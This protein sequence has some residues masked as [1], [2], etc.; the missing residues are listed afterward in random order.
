MKLWKK[1]ISIIALVAMF[2]FLGYTVLIGWGKDGKG[3]AKNIIL[4]LDLN[5]GV[6]VTYEATKEVTVQ[7]MNDVV[8]MMSDRIEKYDGAQAYKEGNDRVTVEIPGKDDALA[9]LEEL[10]KPGAVYFIMEYASDGKTKN[11]E[12]VRYTDGLGNYYYT[13][14]LKKTI[15]EIKEDGTII[16]T[17]EDIKNAEA[18]YITEGVN[19]RVPVVDFALNDSGTSKFK[20]ATTLAAEKGWTI[21][22]YYNG[23]FVSVPSVDEV[24]SDGRGIIKGMSTLD[25]AKDLAEDIRIGALPVELEVVSSQV[26]GASLGQDAISVSLI[27][28]IIGFVILFI[29]MI[30]VYKVPGV[31]SVFALAAYTGLV[32]FVLNVYNFSLTLPG[33]AG[34]ILGIGMAVDANVIVFARIKEEIAKDVPVSGAIR[35]GFK[36]ALSAIIDGNVTTLIAAIVLAVLGSGAIR[37][38]AITLIISIII[39]L[40]SSLLVTRWVLTLLYHLG[41]KAEKYYGRVKEK[42]TYDYVGKRKITMSISAAVIAVGVIF[43]II[44]SSSG[45]GIFNLDLEF[46]GGSSTSVTFDKEYT[47]EEVESDIIPLIKDAT[48]VKTVQQQIVKGSKSIVFKTNF[49]SDEQQKEL[50][51]MFNEKFGV[52][53]TDSNVI[54]SQRISATIGQEMRTKAIIAI[55]IAVTL[56]LIYIWVRFRDWKFAVASIIALAHDV[57]I[58]LAFYVVSRMPVGNTFIACVLTILGYSINATIVIFDRIRENMVAMGKSTV[59]DVVNTSI[60]QTLSRSINTSLTT[61]IMVFVLFIMGTSAIRQ[62]AAPIMV[63][64]VAGTFSSVFISGALWFVMKRASI[65]RLLKSAE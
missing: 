45:K 21:G 36:K 18:V 7:E 3:S 48:G 42:K 25:A 50:Y 17:G 64:I 23:E 6:S 34:V 22:V 19:S 61:F 33:L 28:G 41:F 13:Y 4:G 32:M 11:Y 10:G 39:S 43:L 24:I 20:A 57:L 12:E 62:F 9:V 53:I 8:Q 44:N 40:I 26:V 31:A 5:G 47:L 46:S 65:K 60:G 16:M 49:L 30:V 35:I 63:G 1:I 38:F 56:M 2:G 51:S 27:A 58:V 59:T 29:F 55:A 14:E 52:D 15:D 37:G 54:S